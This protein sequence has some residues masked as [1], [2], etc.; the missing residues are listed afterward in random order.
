MIAL[1]QT[2]HTFWRW[3][4]TLLALALSFLI[5]ATVVV[6]RNWD[7]VWWFLSISD[8][9][10][11]S[12]RYIFS[13]LRGITTQFSL[14]GASVVVLFAI[15]SSVNLIL[16]SVYVVTQRQRTLDTTPWRSTAHGIGGTTAAILGI[17]CATCG[18]AVV[19]ALL[20]IFGATGLLSVLPLGGEE[21]G[22]VGLVLL[23]YSAYTLWRTLRQPSV[24]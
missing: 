24:C 17:G 14:V 16:L 13:L 18:T 22:L 9:S 5:F 2:H 12:V 4:H 3:Y 7:S 15:L 23:A 1:H 10:W 8:S 11:T 20:S 19:F 21:F 6:L